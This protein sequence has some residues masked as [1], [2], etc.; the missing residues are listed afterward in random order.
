MRR[1]S[2]MVGMAVLAGILAVGPSANAGVDIGFG[3]GGRYTD[4]AVDRIQPAARPNGNIIGTSVGL[5]GLQKVM[6]NV[7][8]LS[9]QGQPTTGFGGTGRVSIDTSALPGADDELSEPAGTVVLAN[10]SVLVQVVSSIGA[11]FLA[12]RPDG[13]LDPSVNGDGFLSEQFVACGK[14]TGLVPMPGGGYASVSHELPVTPA[15]P[16]QGTIIRRYD[17]NLNRIA[18][19]NFEQNS[20]FMDGRLYAQSMAAGAGGSVVAVGVTDNSPGIAVNQ[21]GVARYTAAGLPDAGFSEDGIAVFDPAPTVPFAYYGGQPGLPRL[22]EN[23]AGIDV[24]TDASGR[25]LVVGSS[26]RT[27]GGNLQVWVARLDANGAL[28][29]SYGTGGIAWVD[30]SA[31]DDFALQIDV[32]ASGRAVI[33]GTSRPVGE[34]DPANRSAFTIRLTDTGALDTTATTVTKFGTAVDHVA[35]DQILVGDRAIVGGLAGNPNVAGLFHGFIGAIEFSAGPPQ[36]GA[37]FSGI[38]PVRVLD[39][40]FDLGGAALGPNSTRNIDLS[41]IVPASATGV[42]VNV[43]LADASGPTYLSAYPGGAERPGT[44]ILNGVPHQIATNGVVV[45]LGASRS[46]NVYNFANTAEVIVDVQGW[47]NPRAGLTSITPFR[48]VDTRDPGQ[49]ALGAAQLRRVQVTGADVPAGA[50]AVV[51]N[52]TAVTPS[53]NTYLSVGPGLAAGPSQTTSLLNPNQGQI[54]ANATVVGLD[55]TGGFDVYNFAGQTDFLVDVLGWFDGSGGFVPILPARTVSFENIGPGQTKRFAAVPSGVAAGSVGAVS[56]NLT[57]A[58]VSAPTFLTMW[59]EGDERPTAS[60]L[61][62]VPGSIGSN[63]FVVGVGADGM[64]NVY[65]HGGTA[66]IIIDVL[67]WT[68]KA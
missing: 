12:V 46:I 65:N 9:P 10:G 34:A 38:K 14:V 43:T 39:T 47:F 17:A 28:D 5:K 40:R 21:V 41:A 66:T 15:K 13:T 26:A 68:P 32:D 57:A 54:L 25:T 49:S 56:L 37:A 33:S 29:A 7:V 6:V 64:V 35:F 20:A 18:F 11:T 3:T 44:S 23:K 31:N 51:A 4:P 62:P 67:G 55:A 45:G 48:V 52:I 59:P 27:A 50:K 42:A 60:V 30:A 53:A 61:N 22:Y 1:R 2:V 24:A 19:G 16:C 58:D 63:S 8:E 36:G